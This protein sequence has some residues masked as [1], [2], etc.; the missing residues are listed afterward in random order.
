MAK[1]LLCPVGMRFSVNS[2]YS[3]GVTIVVMDS[4]INVRDFP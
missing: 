3:V 1:I 2:S 4:A